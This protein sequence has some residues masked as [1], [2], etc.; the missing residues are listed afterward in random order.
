METNN[1]QISENPESETPEAPTIPTESTESLKPVSQSEPKST[2]SSKPL[3]WCLAI[4]ATIGIVAA[5]VFAYLYFT[6]TTQSPNPNSNNNQSSTAAGDST[7]S[8]ET[9]DYILADY[10]SLSEISVPITFPE[11]IEK[12][13]TQ[14]TITKIELTN[15]PQTIIARFNEAQEELI[16]YDVY[17]MRRSNDSGASIN[18]NILSV[19]TIYEYNGVY[20]DFWNAISLNYDLN[21]KQELSNNELSTTYN[22][23]GKKIYDT[24]L[25][26]LVNSVTTESFF[27]DTQGGVS[28]STI[29]LKDFTEKLQDYEKALEGRLDII[30]MYVDNNK[31]HVLYK[32]SEILEAL[33]MSTNMGSGLLPEIQDISF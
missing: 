23:T 2:K 21:T 12:G 3:I 5:A 13:H 32:Q 15:L 25:N 16:N 27:L 8:E 7:A 28:G 31:L 19:Y 10:V 14:D 6:A 1:N 26:Q 33:G 22:V 17:T 18:D 4:L 30:K 29:S 24:I 9:S 20:G 11:E